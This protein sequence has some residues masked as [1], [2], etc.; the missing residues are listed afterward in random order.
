MYFLFIFLVLLLYVDKIRQTL[1]ASSISI[2]FINGVKILYFENLFFFGE[3]LCF[4]F[5]LNEFTN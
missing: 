3:S 5:F 2:L 4:F 1:K